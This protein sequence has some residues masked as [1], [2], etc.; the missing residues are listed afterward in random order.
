MTVV[1]QVR[2]PQSAQLRYRE[3]RAPIVGWQAEREAR[4][5]EQRAR[6]AAEARIVELEANLSRSRRE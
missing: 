1:S 4:E 3:Q 5:A 2:E 6:E